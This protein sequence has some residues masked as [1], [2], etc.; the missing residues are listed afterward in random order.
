MKEVVQNRDFIRVGK[1]RIQGTGVFAKRKIP[2]GTRIIE[3][4]GKRVKKE[5]LRDEYHKGLT[6]MVYVLSLDETY[7]IDGERE[8]N[9]ARFINHS[10]QPNCE[11]Y[12]F[13]DIAYVY[14][15]VEIK[16]GTELT[17]DYKLQSA[18]GNQLTDKQNKE[19]FPCYCGSENCRGTLIAK[20]KR[21]KRTARS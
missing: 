1:S 10:C 3:Y 17:F 5:N 16:R 11:I 13:D 2:R 20:V 4:K 18:S 7:A 9:D 12:I 8:G 14:A 21:Q 19:L 15:A 6:S